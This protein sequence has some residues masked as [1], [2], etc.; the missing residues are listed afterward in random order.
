M[1]VALLFFP[2]LG[3]TLGIVIFIFGTAV[4]LSDRPGK[5]IRKEGIASI[6]GRIANTTASLC[7]VV[8]IASAALIAER[9]WVLSEPL[10]VAAYASIVLVACCTMYALSWHAKKVDRDGQSNP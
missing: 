8:F 1:P 4:A 7:C 9:T 10:A 3:I 5:L 2:L 6:L